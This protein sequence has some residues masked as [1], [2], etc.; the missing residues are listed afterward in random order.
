MTN[1]SS[2]HPCQPE[3]LVSKLQCYKRQ[4]PDRSHL[5]DQNS[6]FWIKQRTTYDEINYWYNLPETD[7]LTSDCK[8]SFVLIVRLL[9]F[10]IMSFRRWLW[11]LNF[12]S[13]VIDWAHSLIF[14]CALHPRLMTWLDALSS[15]ALLLF[16]SLMMFDTGPHCW[17]GKY[18]LALSF[19]KFWSRYSAKHDDLVVTLS[20]DQ[21]I[22]IKYIIDWFY[23]VLQKVLII[24]KR[25]Y[26]LLFCLV[27][28]LCEINNKYSHKQRYTVDWIPK[29]RPAGRM[30]KCTY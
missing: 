13:H 29:N 19:I 6:T 25:K 26:I 10:W 24:T 27:L 22:I 18:D 3:N 4:W 7:T 16:S 17:L 14:H 1:L 28:T 2:R 20:W 23:F 30:T 15:P 8:S 12:S 9:I 21:Q 5:T 11:S